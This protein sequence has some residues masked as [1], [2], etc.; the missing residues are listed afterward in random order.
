MGMVSNAVGG[1]TKRVKADEGSGAGWHEAEG[2]QLCSHSAP[3]SALPASPSF[4][5]Y[6]IPDVGN[7]KFWLTTFKSISAHGVYYCNRASRKEQIKVSPNCKEPVPCKFFQR[8]HSASRTDKAIPQSH[9]HMHLAE[10]HGESKVNAVCEL[11]FLLSSAPVKDGLP[12]PL[13]VIMQ[14]GIDDRKINLNRLQSS[15]LHN[16]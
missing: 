3:A 12:R 13:T 14:P 7:N 1:T 9:Q 10:D 16:G 15:S 8:Y 6:H 2:K 5:P 4:L 11:D